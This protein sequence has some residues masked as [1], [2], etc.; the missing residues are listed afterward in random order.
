MNNPL[1]AESIL[2]CTHR[3]EEDA[4]QGLFLDFLA[5]DIANHPERLQ[6]IDVRLVARIQSL[7]GTADIDLDAPLS[8]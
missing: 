7:V 4:L 1:D 8:T 5:K 3:Q 6:A 2:S